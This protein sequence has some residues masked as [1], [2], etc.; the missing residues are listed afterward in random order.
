VSNYSVTYFLEA[1]TNV[2]GSG[3]P[4]PVLYVEP[5]GWHGPGCISLQM[6]SDITA[7][8]RVKI[9][10][11][12]LKGV[13]AWRDTIVEQVERERTASDELEAARAEIARLKAEAG[14]DA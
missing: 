2:R 13:T 10:E 8:E 6:R 12:F 1:R 4:N 3:A 11:Q 7:E 9:A 5:D 14:E